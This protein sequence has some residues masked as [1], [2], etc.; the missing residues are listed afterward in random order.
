[1]KK[2]LYTSA[3]IFMNCFI[4]HAQLIYTPVTNGLNPVTFEGGPGEIEVGDIDNDGDLDI[5]SIGD[6]G[7]PMINATETGIMVWKNN[8]TGTSWS[9]TQQGGFGYGG[10]ALG[11]VNNDGKMDIGYGMHHNYSTT[12]FGNQIMEVALGDGAGNSWTPYDDSLATNG[13]DWGMFGTDFADVNSDGL[14]DIGANSF[15]CCW[16][17]VIY[18]SS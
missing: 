15:G 10:C 11:D 1:M 12:D 16:R 18:S 17:S 5:V 13:E 8:G 6:H 14:L 3:A 4:S 9:Q 2:I 7:S